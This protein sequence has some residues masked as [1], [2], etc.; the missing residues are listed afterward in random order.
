MLNTA[1]S[2]WK[3]KFTSPCPY[4][5]EDWHFSKWPM[6]PFI[7]HFHLEV[8]HWRVIW[9]TVVVAI[10]VKVSLIGIHS[11]KWIWKPGP[12]KAFLSSVNLKR[13][14]WSHW[15]WI[16]ISWDNHAKTVLMITSTIGKGTDFHMHWMHKYLFYISFNHT[17]INFSDT[18][19]RNYIFMEQKSHYTRITFV[20]CLIYPVSNDRFWSCLVLF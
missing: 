5:V 17:L 12:L 4:P 11:P 19:L 3:L 18:T 2:S 10:K 7:L 9:L 20:L 14:V 16:I 13:G 8:I 15:Q 1:L 6:E